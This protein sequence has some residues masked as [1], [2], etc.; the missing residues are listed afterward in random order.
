MEVQKVFYTYKHY[1]DDMEKLGYLMKDVDQVISIYRGSLP[2][3]THISNLYDIPLGIIDFQSRDGNSKKPKWVKNAFDPKNGIPKKVLVLDDIYDSGTTMETIKEWLENPNAWGTI[4]KPDFTYL[5]I[6][7]KENDINVK[8][9]R[10]HTG[11]WIEFWW[12]Y[13][14]ENK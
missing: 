7:G 13:L 12:E 4:Q 14:E 2:M 1:L 10:Q 5:T 6:F 3:G 11:D 9:L 8:Y